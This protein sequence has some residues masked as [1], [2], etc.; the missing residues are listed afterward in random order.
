MQVNIVSPPIMVSALLETFYKWAFSFYKAFTD[1]MQFSGVV[2]QGVRFHFS[3]SKMTQADNQIE[4]HKIW[5]L[6][7]VFFDALLNFTIPIATLFF[8]IAIYRSLVTK[9]SDE[10][11]KEL[12]INIIRYV[13]VL[14][15]SLHL[16]DILEWITLLTEEITHEFYNGHYEADKKFFD[17]GLNVINE[18]LKNYNPPT[19]KE[20]F[21]G[22]VQGFFDDIFTYV[23]YFLGALLTLAVFIGTG[24]SI[25]MATINRIV[26]PLLMA[27]F[28]T[29]VLGIGVC[30]G[31][32]Q[33]MLWNFVKNYLGLCLSGVFILIAL[34]MAPFLESLDLFNVSSVIGSGDAQW[35]KAVVAVIRIN[36]PVVLTAGLVKSADAFM[37]KVF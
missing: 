11:P 14:V 10:Q 32:G 30:S 33:R 35:T 22:N 5:G 17:A 16:F 28:S 34:K 8:V 7:K 37:G 24:Y 19:L 15:V 23:L 26:K 20:L 4:W 6:V 31:T 21:K 1:M 29:I 36:L 18:A 13:V 3:H 25:L 12:V 27:P 9:P 2:N